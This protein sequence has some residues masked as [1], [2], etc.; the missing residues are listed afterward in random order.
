MHFALLGSLWLTY[1]Q[2]TPGIL[3]LVKHLLLKVISNWEIMVKF[4][5][6]HANMSNVYI[7]L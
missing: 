4:N 1:T 6:C 5:L 2:K 7:S 3:S